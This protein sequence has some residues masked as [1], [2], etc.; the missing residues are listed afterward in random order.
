V[1]KREFLAV[2]VGLGWSGVRASLDSKP[3]LGP[4]LAVGKRLR[5]RHGRRKR[6]SCL[7]VPKGCPTALP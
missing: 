1:N 3:Q 6:R 7:G 2:A 5:S 4:D